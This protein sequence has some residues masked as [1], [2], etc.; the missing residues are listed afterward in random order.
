M[1]A[2]DIELRTPEHLESTVTDSTGERMGGVEYHGLVAAT[3][4][5]LGQTDERLAWLRLRIM[6]R[7][8]PN[9]FA[10]SALGRGS[11]PRKNTVFLLFVAHNLPAL[12]AAFPAQ[13]LIEAAP[14]SAAGKAQ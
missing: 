9:S 7:V 14:A 1:S 12:E 5:C 2:Q 10:Y 3:R 4:W 11:P 8:P 13:R 6:L